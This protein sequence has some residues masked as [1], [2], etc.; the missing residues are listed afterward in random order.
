MTWRAEGDCG[1]DPAEAGE[2]RFAS[3]TPINAVSTGMLKRPEP[4]DGAPAGRETA[5]RHENG[6]MAIDGPCGVIHNLGRIVIP[7]NESEPRPGVRG[8]MIY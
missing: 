7:L 1:P 6:T 4:S 5:R 3:A 2:R 8:S